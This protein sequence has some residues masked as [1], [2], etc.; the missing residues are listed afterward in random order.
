KVL[1]YE[2]NF[3]LWKLDTATGKTSEV[4]IDIVS[5]D[6]ENEFSLL[7]I[8]NAAD[9]YDLSPSTKRAVISAHGEIFTIAVDRGDVTRVT[10]SYA[11]DVNPKWSPDGKRIAYVSDQSGR[12]E[13]WI[14]DVDGKNAKQ[15]TDANSEKSTLLFSTDSKSL[16]Y[17]A[18][19]HKLYLI[20]LGTGLGKVVAQNEVGNIQNAAFSPDGKWISYTKVDSDLRPHV[21]IVSSAG[22]D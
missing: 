14:A 13:V 19:D 3:G 4:K 9:S 2:E 7:T 18:S 20:D 8:R 17:S 16:A 10:H 6:K 21:C 5:D 11:R 22:G 12:E 15:L 1:V